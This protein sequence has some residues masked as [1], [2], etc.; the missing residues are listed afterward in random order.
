VVEKIGTTAYKLE[1]PPGSMVHPVFHISQLK[2]FTPDSTPTFNDITKLQD[3]T[4]VD[5]EP[6]QVLERRLV[7]KG[8]SAI[9]QVL[10]KWRHL[11]RNSATWEDRYVL[12][13]RF[14]SSVAWGQSTSSAGGRCH[15]WSRWDCQPG[16]G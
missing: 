4:A 15:A 9:P 13:Q 7:K 1:L 3:F 8:N 6:E 11:P 16:G 10:I 2:P 12:K 14:P 5:L